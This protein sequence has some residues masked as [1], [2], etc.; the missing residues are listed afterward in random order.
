MRLHAVLVLLST[1]LARSQR[2]PAA[3][4]AQAE[5]LRASSELARAP[6]SLPWED[7][8]RAASGAPLPVGG[9]HASFADTQGLAAALVAPVPVGLDAEWLHRPRWAAARERFREAGELALLGAD[10]AP[11]VLALW[12]AKEALLKLA[13]AGLADLGRCRL[14]GRDGELY[15]LE[16]R[17]REHAVRVRASGQHVLACAS[18]APAELVLHPLELLTRA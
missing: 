13:G 7:W 3:R 17:C 9:W 4:E 12:T 6:R 15:R 14:L 2:H 11:A 1:R 8:P 5:A 18:A 16:L 10:D